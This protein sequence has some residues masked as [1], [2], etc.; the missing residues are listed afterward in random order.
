MTPQQPRFT[1]SAAT[2][3]IWPWEPTFCEWCDRELA[4]GVGESYGELGPLLCKS[5]V[6]LDRC[7]D[8]MCHGAGYCMHA[9]G[10]LDDD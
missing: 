10:P 8:D 4:V 3:E 1:V 7:V 9:G 2:P 5:C 6:G